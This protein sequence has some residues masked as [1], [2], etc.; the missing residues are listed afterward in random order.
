MA[1]R[2]DDLISTPLHLN[3][4]SPAPKLLTIGMHLA[5]DIKLN[6]AGG[7]DIKQKEGN[8]IRGALKA[9]EV[10]CDIE[11]L[12]IGWVGIQ[13][14]PSAQDALTST[15]M[16]NHHSYP[17][18]LTELQ[19]EEFYHRFCKGVLWPTMNYSLATTRRFDDIQAIWSTYKKIMH[20]I[21]DVVAT[22]YRPGDVIWIHDYHLFCLPAYIRHRLPNAKIG[23]F[24]HCTFPSSELFRQ[25]PI[26]ESILTGLCQAD[27]IGFQTYNYCRY[28]L[29]SVSV[30]LDWEYG[31]TSVTDPT[32]RVTRVHVDPTGLTVDLYEKKLQLPAVTQQAEAWRKGIYA[33]TKIVT[34]RCMRLDKYQGIIEKLLAF[35]HFLS[36]HAEWSEKVILIQSIID[37]PM[38]EESSMSNEQE[39]AVHEERVELV[40]H[41]EQLV[42]RINGTHGTLAWQPVHIH[43]K[44]S[45]TI[46]NSL[47]IDLIADVVMITPI[48]D[49]M[50]L[51]SHESVLATHKSHAPLILSEFAGAASC[52]G[53]SIIVNPYD[54]QGMSDALV[55]ALTMSPADK[56]KNHAH[57][58]RY[59]KHNTVGQWAKVCIAELVRND[60]PVSSKHYLLKGTRLE[61][62]L[63]EYRSKAKRLLVLDF[64]GTL[65]PGSRKSEVV[66][67]D[68]KRHLAALCAD[69][70]NTVFVLSGKDQR[71]L[72]AW[73]ND[74]PIGLSA[75]HGLYLREPGAKKWATVE[76]GI[77]LSWKTAV[78]TLYADFCDRTPGAEIEE[79]EMSIIWNYSKADQQFARWLVKDLVQVLHQMGDKYPISVVVL[80]DAIEVRPHSLC[81]ASV[82]K[83][84]VLRN[85]GVD[86]VY[87]FGSSYTDN[88][89][90]EFQASGK[91]G[92]KLLSPL[93]LK[94]EDSS[95]PSFI[96][97]TI[98]DSNIPSAA[99]YYLPKQADLPALLENLCRSNYLD[100]SR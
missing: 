89:A 82:C 40:E 38:T 81:K 50:N 99:G 78:R 51:I 57:N 14:P 24:V 94:S 66:S 23:F 8:I 71:H 41:V 42:G 19:A 2:D 76:G 49:G 34:G 67:Q 56:A 73:A 30:L 74:I 35:D 37:E 86:S 7:Y 53:G 25:I 46:E 16:I 22:L 28:F 32:G 6:D 3:A 84:L 55:K 85:R 87:R 61:G 90:L 62:F 77:D 63:E 10:D 31:P 17:L 70:R 65:V 60:E 13:V 91:Q 97:I 59:V 20:Y 69:D 4:N 29:R 93:G 9:L 98:G 45:D 79:H 52:L 100:F 75:A 96:N 21:A 12:N 27:V 80:R 48:R 26:R 92:S 39:Q 54:K 64:E 15:L 68:V 18:F 36:K 47:A 5:V 58:L 88:D 95:T 43:I 72:E 83:Q 11:S 33:N 44:Q 1:G